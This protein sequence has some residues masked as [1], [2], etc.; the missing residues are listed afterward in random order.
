MSERRPLD[1]FKDFTPVGG[2]MRD[3]WLVTV[4]PVLKVNTVQELIALG[5]AR[6]GTLNFPS[7][8][9]GSRCS[10]ARFRPITST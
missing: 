6:P 4:S 5:K 9:T 1:P 7:S 8:G 10:S 2:L 3:H